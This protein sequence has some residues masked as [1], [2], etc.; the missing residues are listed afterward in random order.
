MSPARRHPT[1]V[2]FAERSRELDHEHRKRL[3][4]ALPL[5]LSMRYLASAFER[6]RRG[7]APVR[8]GYRERPGS[9]APVVAAPVPGGSATFPTSNQV[10]PPTGATYAPGTFRFAF[11]V[12][13][14]IALAVWKEKDLDT[15]QRIQRD[16]TISPMLL[17]TV[18][19]AGKTVDEVQRDLETRYK[20]YLRERSRRYSL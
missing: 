4:G 17:G 14:E 15:T 13:D 8:D 16:G 9:D 18:V 20:E 2:G 10:G 6:L 12:G 19:V 1:G 3:R 5:T 11:Q 7:T